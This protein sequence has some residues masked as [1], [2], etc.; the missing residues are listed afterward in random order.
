MN[1]KGLGYI[2]EVMVAMMTL[3]I[4]VMG[5]TVSP[6]SQDW[7]DFQKE[8]SASDLTYTLKQ[9]GH[10]EKMVERRETGSIET[11]IL[12]L[13][14]EQYEVS[15][16]VEGL[17]LNEITV[18]F[19]APD[20]YTRSIR[21]VEPGDEC[22]G[23]LPEL[24]EASD[25][26]SPVQRVGS[27]LHD[28]VLYFTDTDPEIDGF[29]GETNYDSLW[30]DN[31][32]D[33]EQ[34]QFSEDDGPF[35]TD[36]FFKWGEGSDYEYYDFKDI[37][38]DSFSFHDGTQAVK[39]R[40]K[41]RETLNG[42]QTSQEFDTFRFEETDIDRYDIVILRT[43]DT[44]QQLDADNDKREEL[45]Q[46]IETR[47]VLLMTNLTENDFNSGFIPD[48]GME[49]VDLDTTE[50]PGE[51]RFGNSREGNEIS[52]Y[53]RGL[54]G[55]TENINLGSGGKVSSSNSDTFMEENPVVYGREGQYNTD[56]WNVTNYNMDPVDPAD[57]E[58]VPESAC[59]SEGSETDSLTYGEFN[60]ETRNNPIEVLNAEMGSSVDN[61][62]NIR[63]VNFDLNGDGDFSDKGPLLAGESFEIDD[64]R[65]LVRIVN[66]PGYD[67]G[68]AIDL[69]FTGDS[70]IEIVN[71]RDSFE[72]FRGDR[73]ARIPYKEEYSEDERKLAA[74]VIYWL[75]RDDI[76]FGES[77]AGI[78]TSTVGSMNENTYMPYKLS[79]RW[80]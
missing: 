52:M 78:S 7:N 12:A 20:V 59:Y 56:P 3:F 34:C 63:S 68:Q 25:P 26:A 40:E 4:F 55:S 8:I 17:P 5:N 31:Q 65:Y 79:L 58:G 72:D 28:T 16:T 80:E 67:D 33:T 73:L 70:D 47:P 49:W 27:P 77:G 18:G 9:T 44:L 53:L 41:M 36:S 11:S 29:D 15:G 14:D 45:E 30:V 66:E 22:F 10:M 51:P 38:E 74:S 23:N 19:N 39:I 37:D 54:E 21:E 2:I 32:T 57:Y 24:E 62:E 60:F 69:V 35:Y 1:R 46:F 76:S 75:V 43:H 42:I 48:T 64:R 13:T 6:P 71:Y 50:N 61:C